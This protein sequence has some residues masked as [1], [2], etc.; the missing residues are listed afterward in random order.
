MGAV[1]LVH[2][3]IG[4]RVWVTGR[5]ELLWCPVEGE[6]GVWRVLEADRGRWGGGHVGAEILVYDVRHF[7]DCGVRP[8][9]TGV[10]LVHK[11]VRVYLLEQ[12]KSN[13][14]KYAPQ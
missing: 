2:T 9:R 10:P 4:V 6:C 3:R 12:Q 14:C 7:L 13:K 11:V 5:D 8:G 1:L